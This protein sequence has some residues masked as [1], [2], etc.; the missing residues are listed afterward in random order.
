MYCRFLILT[1]SAVPFSSRYWPCLRFA[2]NPSRSCEARAVSSP[3]E[4]DVVGHRVVHGG[5]AF[6]DPVLITPKVKSAIASVS[7][8]APL[9]NRAEL[10]G[11]EIIEQLLGA[12]SQVAV[13]DTGFHKTMPLAAAVYPGPYEWFTAGIRRYGFHGINHKYCARRAAHRLHRDPK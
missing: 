11:M 7:A 13:F 1:Q 6:E 9:H 4:I 3:T 5:P 8:F 2:T 12:V 10:E